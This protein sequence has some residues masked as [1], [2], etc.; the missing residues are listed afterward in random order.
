MGF[1]AKSQNPGKLSVGNVPCAA[2]SASA[3]PTCQALSQVP[4]PSVPGLRLP[5]AAP[6]NTMVSEPMSE[7]GT[8]QCSLIESI[9]L[10]NI[11]IHP[12]LALPGD[13]SPYCLLVHQNHLLG[14]QVLVGVSMALRGETVQPISCLTRKET[15]AERL[16]GEHQLSAPGQKQRRVRPPYPLLIE[17]TTRIDDTRLKKPRGLVKPS[18]SPPTTHFAEAQAQGRKDP[19]KVTQRHATEYSQGRSP[20][21]LGHRADGLASASGVAQEKPA[22]LPKK[23]DRTP[24][25]H[26]Q[27][28]LSPAHRIRQTHCLISKPMKTL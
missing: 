14:G 8:S 11:F 18:P 6:R 28:S 10:V 4:T 23:A 9:R 17:F 26:P 24:R 13:S 2:C 7:G 19:A 22:T 16:A 21:V 25:D 5:M 27:A 15:T 3:V 1:L 12:T 20:R